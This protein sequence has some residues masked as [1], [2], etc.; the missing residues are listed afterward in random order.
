MNSLTRPEITAEAAQRLVASAL[1]HA[2]S[3]GWQIAV[4]VVD[5]HGVLAAFGRSDHVAR[6][7]VEFAIDKAYTAATL[8]KSSQAFG[9]RMASSPT[10]ALGLSTRARLMAWG[11]GVAVF[12]GD[13]C[14]AGIGVSGVQ[15]FEDVACAQAVIAA[16][17]LTAG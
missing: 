5:P 17:G 8:R 10:L 2:R 14:I 11:G 12:E 6:P 7:S 15:D 4:A 3:N 9:E 13:A 1:D 16:V